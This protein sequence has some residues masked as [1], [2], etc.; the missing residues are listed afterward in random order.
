MLLVTLVTRTGAAV[1]TASF[2]LRDPIIRQQWWLLPL[3]DILGFFVWMGGF[4]GDK[5]VWRD[6]KIT[7][8][9][10]GRLEVNP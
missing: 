7:V 10:D 3:Q 8:L 2:V 4:L 1:A 5:I 6:R 9:R